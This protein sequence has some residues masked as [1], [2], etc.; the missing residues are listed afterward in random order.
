MAAFPVVLSAT[1]EVVSCEETIG[2][3][4]V[5]WTFLVQTAVKVPALVGEMT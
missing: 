1:H 5:R 3:L 2:K 4:V